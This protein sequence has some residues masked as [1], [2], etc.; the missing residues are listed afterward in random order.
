LP[1]GG[2]AYHSLVG[3]LI[4]AVKELDARVLRLEA[5]HTDTQAAR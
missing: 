4:E 2:W 1:G 5:D 3:P